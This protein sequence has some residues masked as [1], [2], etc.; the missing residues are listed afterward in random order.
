MKSFKFVLI[1]M[2]CLLFASGVFGLAIVPSA[3]VA[4]AIGPLQSPIPTPKPNPGI[5]CFVRRGVTANLR[6]GP[7]TRYRIKARLP[8]G[9]RFVRTARRGAWWYGRTAY[10][11]G[12]VLGGLLTCR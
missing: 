9:T 7:G 2:V 4:Q 3:G 11:V 5:G 1:C 12:W 6:S 8:G 10:G